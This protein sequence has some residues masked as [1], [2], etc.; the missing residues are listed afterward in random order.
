MMRAKNSSRKIRFMILAIAAVIFM[1][2]EVFS[3]FMIGKILSFLIGE[4]TAEEAE[5]E[6]HPLIVIASLLN[7]RQWPTKKAKAETFYDFGEQIQ[8]TGQWSRD[9]EWIEVEGGENGTVWVSYK[10]VTERMAPFTVTNENNG[11]IKIRSKPGGG[12][13]LKGY[14]RH[15]KSIEIDQVV[16]GYG[17]CSKGW[18]DLEYFVEEVENGGQTR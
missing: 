18:V 14:V 6:Y 1:V 17:H 13:K 12:G 15:G 2:M 8:P 9:C 5:A 3:G 10:Y 11:R 4:A 16:M 7:G